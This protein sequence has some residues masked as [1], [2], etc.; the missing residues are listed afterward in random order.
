MNQAISS[1]P[2]AGPGTPNTVNLRDYW[3]I[4]RGGLWT[5]IA[6]FTIVVGLVA[7][8]TFTQK[9]IYTSVATVEVRTAVRRPMGGQDV[10]DM[11][12][13]SYSWTAEERF[14]N[15]QIEILKSRDLAQRVVDKMGLAADPM[16]QGN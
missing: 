3:K 6:V 13:Q 16:F 4:V 15:T 10:S 12:V 5:I 11:G 9:P 14:Y 1:P 7:L 8:W 2:N